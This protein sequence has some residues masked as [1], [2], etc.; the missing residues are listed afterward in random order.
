M[1]ALIQRTSGATVLI[2]GQSVGEIGMGLVVFVFVCA[3]RGDGEAE[4]SRLPGR[5]LTCASS[6]TR[7]AA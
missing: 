4:S 1:R 3:M 7:R 6:A 2:D 5:R